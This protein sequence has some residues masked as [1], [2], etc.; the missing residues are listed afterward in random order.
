MKTGSLALP[1]A[2]AIGATCPAA[3]V[4]SSEFRY[5]EQL[6]EWFVRGDAAVS[7]SPAFPRGLRLAAWDERDP[8]VANR[9][10]VATAIYFFQVPAN[11]RS[12]K[13]EACY[14]AAPESA[15]KRIAGFILVRNTAV[16][17]EYARKYRLEATPAE[18]PAFYGH[19]YLLPA[20]QVIMTLDI[21][22]TDHVVD[23]VL[24]VHLSAGAGQV[25]DLLYVKV[26]AFGD[27]VAV[28]VEQAP[29]TLYVVNP[30][31]YTY[32]YY[33]AGPWHWPRGGVFVRFW[34]FDETLDP[35]WWDGWVSFRAC[36]F[37][38]HPW[39]YRPVYYVH[40]PIIVFGPH[41][42]Q[43]SPV[44]IRYRRRWYARRFCVNVVDFGDPSLL[45]VVRRPR[46]Y[47][48]R[49]L[50]ERRYR[51]ALVVA[52]N[53]RFA[54]Y[55]LRSRLGPSFRDRLRQWRRDPADLRRQIDSMPRSAQI[56]SAS[57]EWKKILSTR[58]P[59]PTVRV[60]LP[61]PTHTPIRRRPQTVRTVRTDRP[62]PSTIPTTSRTGYRPRAS[63]RASQGGRSLRAARGRTFVP[64]LRRAPPG[65][66]P[67]PR[68]ATPR[69]PLARC[70][71]HDRVR[72]RRAG[73]GSSPSRPFAGPNWCPRGRP[74]RPSPGIQP[75]SP[76]AEGPR[77]ALCRP[78]EF[79]RGPSARCPR[80]THAPGVG[81]RSP[82]RRSHKPLRP[83]T[84]PRRGA[85]PCSR[86][87]GCVRC[88]S[89]GR[90]CPKNPGAASQ[91]RS[92]TEGRLARSVDP[93]PSRLPEPPQPLYSALEETTRQESRRNAPR[94]LGWSARD[95][96]RRSGR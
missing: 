38:Y 77:T 25:L 66:R 61:T 35:F 96:Q 69:P 43:I 22:T 16:E 91:R 55:E 60:P 8:Q 50:A 1:L 27:E 32:I 26:T 39:V 6:N 59:V 68:P 64:H 30:Y 54:G 48:P 95:G 18:E 80:R 11:A 63:I 49:E 94:H 7:A 76:R 65:S 46:R 5:A 2:L 41:I 20:D 56:K 47:L 90:G 3:P 78:S 83:A 74:G 29:S 40:R 15:D 31:Q 75:W 12:L 72:N 93:T 4:V 14:R 13:I 23:G 87:R 81:K 70:E 52:D 71:L 85:P 73:D 28:R 53:V 84:R 10:A 9:V 67:R 86:R 17:R 51:Q 58:R 92:P 36:F 79:R 24:E 44:I 45:Y 37:A 42:C 33:Y 62:T 82:R 21:P 57:L 88:H 19:T 89:W 34:C